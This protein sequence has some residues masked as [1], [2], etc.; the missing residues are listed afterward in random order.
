M[1]N[2]KLSATITIGGAISSTLKSAF[3][4][5]TSKLQGITKE[6]GTLS[7]AQKN[8]GN[9]IQVFGRMGKNV[10]GLREKYAA[11]TASIAR[12]RREQ[13]RLEAVESRREKIGA[14]TSKMRTI[15]AT[16]TAAGAVIGAP[17]VLGVKEAKHYD[18]EKARV[19][20]LG[21]GPD[22]T[23]KAIDFAAAMKTFG[24]SQTENLEL[25][26]DAMSVFGNLEH[27]QMVMPLLAKM[28]FGN[29]AMF[30]AGHGEENTRQFM[31]M[32]K[33]I[34]TRGGLSSEGEFNK[35]ANIIQQVI[36]ATGGRV[37]ATEWRN[38]I[39][40]GGLAAKG[41]S[42][43]A[44]YY[45]ME[46]LVQEQGGDKVGTGLSAAYGN[47]YQGR[48]SV[49]AAR[50]LEKLGLIGDKSKVSND[51][52]GQVSHLDP[53][54]LLGSDIF[55]R[56]Q[57]E[58]LKQVLL[59]AL[60]K[61]GLT[62]KDQVLDAIGSIFTN[63]KAAD[64]FG[65][66]YLQQE[67]I[68]KS[69]KLNR[70]ADN[71]DQLDQQGRASAA[72][73]EIDAE[74]KLADLK[75]RMGNAILPMYS[76]ALE[77]AAGALE[78][79]NKETDRHPRL[80][81]AMLI[82]LGSLAGILTIG[83]PLLIG[84]AVLPAAIGGVSA[85][86]GILSAAALP[87]AA[88]GAAIVLLSAGAYLLYK[89]WEPVKKFFSDLWDDIGNI[90]DGGIGRV[91]TKMAKLLPYMTPSGMAGAILSNAVGAGLG[92]DKP[93]PVGAPALPVPQLPLLRGAGGGAPAVH[94]HSQ[95]TISIIQK[96]DQSAEELAKA[97][98]REM[99][100]QRQVRSRSIMFDPVTP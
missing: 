26:R 91:I 16:A 32:L 98:A 66:M 30:G 69:E 95:V 75:L 27:A 99:A 77:T 52:S 54:A 43:E 60:A 13:E 85:A 88:I 87:L 48:T 57:Y 12:L 50:N 56:S 29:T 96:P 89:N 11:A 35:Q 22:T 47:L 49:R 100:K 24:T 10:D 72:G 93:A 79:L 31:D 42:D 83:G 63:K 68:E 73:K 14:V 34:E 51:K 25:M 21:M 71:V 61:K 1:A 20:A 23:K 92:G 80:A 82:G 44:L 37:N 46:H 58:W 86:F 5:T 59:P 17:L 8:L 41:M 67:Q 36:S 6:I 81:N 19:A 78:W 45:T 2:K 18:S 90:F 76:A 3:G 94:D 38:L 28:K 62:S 97:V 65:S 40:T 84:L 53:G 70:G 7:R 9:S 39:S 4:T 64:L 74:K 55:R 15:G 33:V